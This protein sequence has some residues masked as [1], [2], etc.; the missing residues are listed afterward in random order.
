MLTY[1]YTLAHT[2][3]H[4]HT[5]THPHTPTHAP[6]HAHACTLTHIHVLTYASTLATTNSS[7][8]LAFS[9]KGSPITDDHADK[10][11]TYKHGHYEPQR[12]FHGEQYL[13]DLLHKC[14]ELPL[15]FIA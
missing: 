7:R 12:T 1:V 15:E 10:Q 2:H 14:R 9:R 11:I 3:T 6:T 5:Q 8:G 13:A 4:T